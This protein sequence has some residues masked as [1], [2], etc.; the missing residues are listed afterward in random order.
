MR[1]AALPDSDCNKKLPGLEGGRIDLPDSHTKSMHR[2]AFTLLVFLTACKQPAPLVAEQ[3]ILTTVPFEFTVEGNKLV[4]LMDKPAHQEPVATVI[5]VHGY[6]ATNVVENNWHYDL[7][8]EFAKIG[9]NTVM[10]DKPGCGESEGTFDINQPV[11]SSAIEVVAAIQE[12]K[13]QGILDT[14]TIGLWGI[15]RAGWIAPLAI[16]EEPAIDFWISVSGTD[17]KENARYLIEA[18]LRAEGRPESV[19][20]Q[21]SNEWQASF[22]TAWQGGSYQDYLNAAPNLK[23]DDFIQF[24]GWDGVAT[25]EE[26]LDYQNKFT[27][28]ELL[29]D[30]EA[31]LQVYVPA[32]KEVLTSINMPVLALFG[33]KDTN[34]DWRKT[35]QLYQE[36]IGANPNASLTIKTFPDADHVLRQTQTGGIREMQQQ[37][38]RPPYVEGYYASIRTWLLEQEIGVDGGF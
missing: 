22:N 24:M 18:N 10:W 14:H 32:F 11:Q 3:D 25:E 38:S 8:S 30:P 28:G 31:E 19:V 4:G 37:Q 13:K 29:V 20:T 12:L 2:I 6:G 16:Q 36:T 34:V 23:K 5:I 9:I 15:S 35:L 21:L 26:F 7:R 33:E 27:T 17:D 1:A